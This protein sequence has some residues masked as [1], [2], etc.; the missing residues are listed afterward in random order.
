MYTD[1]NTDPDMATVTYVDIKTDQGHGQTKEHQH[2]Q[3]HGHAHGH[4]HRHIH[5]HG[6]VRDH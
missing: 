6:H 4:G 5:G 2:G 3:E 1:V